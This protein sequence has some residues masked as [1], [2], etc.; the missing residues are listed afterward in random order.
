MAGDWQEVI[1]TD[2]TKYGGSGVINENILCSQVPEHGFP[3]SAKVRI[4]PLGTAWFN[5]KN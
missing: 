3:F 2:A 4:P 1:N 5:L